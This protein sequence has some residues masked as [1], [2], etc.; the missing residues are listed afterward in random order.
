MNRSLEHEVFGMVLL[1]ATYSLIDYQEP[2]RG[3]LMQA[4]VY[5][6]E[7]VKISLEANAAA[8]IIAHNHPSG[9][10]EPSQADRQLTQQLQQALALVDIRLLDHIL[11]AGN[12]TMSFAEM[13][14]L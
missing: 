8:I 13:G 2:F 9:R 12:A 4:S 3:T 7:V 10:L 14:L 1:D 5:P 6:R 11:V